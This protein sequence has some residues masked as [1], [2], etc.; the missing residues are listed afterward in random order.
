MPELPPPSLRSQVDVVHRSLELVLHNT[1]AESESEERVAVFLVGLDVL[2]LILS[3]L[4]ILRLRLSRCKRSND[5]G[6]LNLSVLQESFQSGLSDRDDLI[7][8]VPK[9]AF[10]EW[11]GCQGS[12]VSPSSIVIERSDEF[13]QI[14]LVTVT[15][16]LL[17][18]VEH[19]LQEFVM[20]VV[21]ALSLEVVVLNGLEYETEDAVRELR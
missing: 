8:D 6:L 18:V 12:L 2:R 3:K 1:I 14:K 15:C 19:G 16:F 17:L 20:V 7:D 9:D 10:G 5:S 11:G 21:D 13:S 4:I